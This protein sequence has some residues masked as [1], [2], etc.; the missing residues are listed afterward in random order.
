M[1][2]NQSK[3]TATPPTPTK[4]I[5]VGKFYLIHDGSKTGHPGLII[6]K[7]DAHNLYLAIK[8]GS[9]SAKDNVKFLYPLSKDI[10]NSYYYKRLFL[11]KRKNFGT[12]ELTRLTILDNDIGNLIKLLDLNNPTYSPDLHRK[13]KRFF[14]WAI[15]NPLYQ[16]QLS[17]PKGS[18]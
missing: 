15:K 6:W 18:I 11:G 1:S 2:N 3:Q 5:E 16:G 13:D 10:T 12:I 4:V 17:S 9:S 8:F 7:D 14:K